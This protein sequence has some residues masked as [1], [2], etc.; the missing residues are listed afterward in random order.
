MGAGADA[1]KVGAVM[2]QAVVATEFVAYLDLAGMVKSG[3][4]SSRASTIAIYALCGFA[5]LPSIAIQIGG[6]GAMAP[7]RRSEIAA[8]GLR[9]MTAGALACWM[10]GAIAGIF[11]G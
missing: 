7:E 4:I 10:T 11:L 1:H 2:G 8:L 9:A 6:L 3:E 5:N